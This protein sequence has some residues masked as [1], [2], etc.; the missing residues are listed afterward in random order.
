[1]NIKPDHSSQQSGSSDYRK[2]PYCA[3][4]IRNEA[5]ICRYCNR[6]VTPSTNWDEP[7][8]KKEN[9]N[10]V[11]PIIPNS[12]WKCPICG[13]RNPANRKY[14][15]GCNSPYSPLNDIT[16]PRRQ[17]GSACGV[18]IKW[19]IVLIGVILIFRTVSVVFSPGG[20]GS[21]TCSAGAIKDW[22]NTTH[23]LL[24]DS[25]NDLEYV[26]NNIDRV[27]FYYYS[28]RA[29]ERYQ[30]QKRISPPSCL[31]NIHEQ[32]VQLLYYEDQY[33]EAEKNDNYD[34]A[35]ENLDKAEQ[36]FEKINEEIKKIDF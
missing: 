14:C 18:F 29:N 22:V 9:S 16:I 10:I 4:L 6:S 32:V 12:N 26:S 33:Y 15:M 7:I 24:G 5:I 30:D 35:I 2:C 28:D 3:E 8:P 31:S 25:N 1:M 19:I 34:L 11:V 20:I 36:A 17:S 23:K 27:N 13:G 21:F